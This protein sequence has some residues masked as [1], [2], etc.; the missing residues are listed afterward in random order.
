MSSE[1]T[2][3][4]RVVPVP[5]VVPSSG[6][7]VAENYVADQLQS[8]RAGLQRTRIIGIVLMV[9]IVGY[10]SY[11]TI[12][13]QQSLRPDNAAEIASGMISQQVQDKG[14][15]MAE[16][17][18]QRVQA[19]IA[20]LPDYALTQ[21]PE[22]RVALE[23]RL[24]ADLTKHCK[25]TSDLLGQHL[26]QFLEEHK[27]KIKQIL[28]TGQDREAV[29]QMG[30]DLEHQLMEYLKE[31]PANGESVQD[32]IN[33]SLRALREVEATV[34]RLANAKDLNPQERKTRRAIALIA[35]TADQEL[36]NFSIKDISFKNLPINL[37]TGG[38]AE[39]PTGATEPTGAASGEITELPALKVPRGAGV[40]N[41]VKPGKGIGN[42]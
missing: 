8:A 14:P 16:Q 15:E 38:N 33:H 17:A 3:S 40:A 27:D 32:Q 7:A 36:K 23:D 19:M 2:P 18:K 28:T 30:A 10:L 21:L 13:F 35:Q 4:E 24:E 6:E 9:V 31:K 37:P 12:K 42:R 20:G 11:V 34:A 39:A 1:E 29:R 25:E 41:G 5:A 26:D 22:Y